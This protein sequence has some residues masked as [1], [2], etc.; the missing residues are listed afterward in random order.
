MA[1]ESSTSNN[2][3]G[4]R[5]LAPLIALASALV[6]GCSA[7]AP[8]HPQPIAPAPPPRDDGK[9][10]EGGEGGA[11]HAAA[12]EQLKISPLGARVDRQ[13]SLR[14][15]LPD[16]GTWMR[17]KF[18]GMKSLVGFRYGKDHHAIVGG[19][20]V[21]VDDE[22]APGACSKAFEQ[23]AQPYID[24][25]EVVI[26][27]EPPR[28]VPWNGK[29]VDIDAL[30]ATTAT[31]GVRDQYAVAYATYPAWKGACLVLGIAIPARDEIDRAKAV[32][33]RFATEALP[34]VQVTVN[35]EPKELY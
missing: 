9:P 16:A 14:V 12:L 21:H 3:P 27:H 15:S 6:G 4:M 5:S 31:L 19:F 13:E 28:A 23:W 33:D 7:A 11:A 20:V 18:W 8:V 1:W 24:A 22:N 26:D 29:I 10:A 30:V 25:F 34:N 2:W 17:V 35:E 32:R